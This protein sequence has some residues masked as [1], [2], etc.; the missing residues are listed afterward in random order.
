MSRIQRLL[1][2]LGLLLIFGYALYNATRKSTPKAEPKATDSYTKHTHTH[3]S[4]HTQEELSQL[5][6]SAYIK[7]YIIQVIKHG[8]SQLHFKKDEI[9]EGGFAPKEDAEAIACYV[10]SLSGKRCP[11]SYP[12]EAVGYYTSICG[13][14]HGDD[15][16]GLNGTYPDLTRPTLLG[17]DK[18][19]AFLRSKVAQRP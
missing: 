19:E 5:H 15:G 8:S 7:Q 6:T 4:T 2:L 13:G 17:I 14:C 10:M 1:P 18:K 3:R 9:M 11:S 16:K 12:S